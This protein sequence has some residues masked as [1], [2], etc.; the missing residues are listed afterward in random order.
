MQSLAQIAEIH[1]DRPSFQD[2]GSPVSIN[3]SLGSASILRFESPSTSQNSISN[4]NFTIQPQ[5]GSDVIKPNLR[6]HL[7]LQFTLSGS[8]TVAAS[9]DV[10]GFSTQGVLTLKQFPFWQFVQSVSINYNGQTLNVTPYKFISALGLYSELED[11][12]RSGDA[13]QPD[14]GAVDYTEYGTSAAAAREAYNPFLP[15]GSNTKFQSRATYLTFASPVVTGT[16]SPFAFTQVATASIDVELPISFLSE[17]EHG[18]VNITT[19]GVSINTNGRPGRMLSFNT[20][21]DPTL[22]LTNIVLAFP[23]VPSLTYYKVTLPSSVFEAVRNGIFV[24]PTVYEF[25]EHSV[26]D[27]TI[28]SIPAGGSSDFSFNQ[29]YCR[30]IPNQ[31]YVFMVK[32][33]DAADVLTNSTTPTNFGCITKLS[34]TSD[35]KQVDFVAS[36]DMYNMSVENGLK[37]VSWLQWNNGYVGSV[38]CFD[39]NKD[40][41]IGDNYVGGQ[42]PWPI[43]VSGSMVNKSSSTVS[44]TPRIVLIY[45]QALT[46]LSGSEA[47]LS[48]SLVEPVRVESQISSSLAVP[49]LNVIG[50]AIRGGGMYKAVRALRGGGFFGDLWAG[51]KKFTGPIARTISKIAP[52]IGTLLPEFAPIAAGV[53]RVAGSIADETGGA[54]KKGFSV[55]KQRFNAMLK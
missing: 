51:I 35:N 26:N 21:A 36:R 18:L 33:E 12:I 37:N 8:Q 6:I 45:G 20:A 39:F 2:V 14:Y 15:F 55:S 11:E 38:V 54:I 23:T 46:I 29:L 43:N 17:G 42:G 19:F 50:G 13:V 31:M 53:G 34:V 24:K 9:S 7:D 10:T 4:L 28:L 47:T 3:A 41:P 30:K 32:N 44:Y 1:V 40:L 52:I 48:D 49:K 22:S 25:Y 16:A 5:A 27:S